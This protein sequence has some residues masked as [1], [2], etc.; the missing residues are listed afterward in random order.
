MKHIPDGTGRF[1]TRPY[2]EIGEL[3]AECEALVATF[4]QSQHGKVQFP[5]ATDDLTKLI[6]QHAQV[7][8]LYADLK[9]AYGQEVEGVTEFRHDTKPTVRICSTLSEGARSENRLRTT[10]AHEFGHVHFHR[11]LFDSRE[12][13]GQLFAETANAPDIQV[14]KRETILDAAPV[15]WMEWQAGHVSGALLMP[16][17]WIRG[18]AREII[19][20]GAHGMDRVRS[21]D[22]VGMAL[23]DGVATA[24]QVSKVAAKVRLF[25]LGLL[26]E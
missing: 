7:L 8:D 17:S 15:D 10:L 1:P 20:Q 6:E 14:C 26:Q 11:W 16:A 2:Y 19:D 3:D 9:S 18:L 21:I 13:T 12:R 4:M 24:F 25:R 5:F 23:V 22:P